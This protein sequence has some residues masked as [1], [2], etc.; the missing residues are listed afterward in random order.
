MVSG[1]SSPL[2]LVRAVLGVSV[3]PALFGILLFYPPG[4]FAWRRAWMLIGVVLVATV[5]SM[6]VLARANPALLAERFKM[7]VQHGQPTADKVVVLLFLA[8]FLGAIRFVPYDVFAW[9]LLPAPPL[10]VAGLGLVALLG[11]WGIITAAM[12][13]NAFAIPVVKAQAER[14]HVV[15]DRGPYAVVRHPMYAGA[16]LLMFGLPLWLGSTAGVLAAFVP[17]ALL[18][19][20]I[21]VEERFLRG[22]LPGYEAYETRVRWRLVPGLW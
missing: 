18:V 6:L 4:D 12:R 2:T 14:H 5:A 20:R 3:Q 15:V 8:A 13:A 1:M 7:P 9:H 22:A 11:G 10:A 17:V 19:L 21:G 16:V